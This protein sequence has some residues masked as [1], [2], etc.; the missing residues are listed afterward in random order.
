MSFESGC[1]AQMIVKMTCRAQKQ[2]NIQVK[3]IE[4]EWI[5]GASIPLPIACKAIALPFELITLR[6]L[7]CFVRYNISYSDQSN[8]V[9]A[10]LPIQPFV[11]WSAQ[12][13]LCSSPSI[14]C[15]ISPKRESLLFKQAHHPLIEKEQEK[16]G[17]DPETQ[18]LE[19][20][21]SALYPK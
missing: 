12:L 2:N 20:T 11:Q 4:K 1:R 19:S 17:I 15:R 3:K 13:R 9:K 10:S 8:Q 5:M 6:A 14:F 16:R 21:R 7:F 18:S